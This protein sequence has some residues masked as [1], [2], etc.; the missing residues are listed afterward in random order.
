LAKRSSISLSRYLVTLVAALAAGGCGGGDEPTG[1]IP[2]DSEPI[3]RDAYV[4]PLGAAAEADHAR[5]DDAYRRLLI[6]RFTSMTPENAMKWAIIQPERGK[7]DFEEADALVEF[8]RKTGKRVRGHPLVWDDQLPRWVREGDWTPRELKRVMR[9]HIRAV[10]G[11]YRG[12]IAE[13][14]VVNEPLAH[15]GSFEHNIWFDTL[16]PRWVAYAFRVAR[17][18]DPHAKLFLNEIDAEVRGP[19]SR[20]LLELARTLKQ[21]GV[22]IDG[23]GFQHHTTGR[24]APN[25]ARLR[26]LFSATRGIG[27]LAAITEMDVGS[28]E[29]ARQAQVFA[30]AADVCAS[31]SN[32]TGLTVWGVTDAFSWLEPEAEALPFDEDGELKPAAAALERALRR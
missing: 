3:A 31:A 4:K 13:W 10:A 32:C 23:V 12:K 29:R 8:A 28:T 26:A 22:P 16:G 21:K 11:R 6:T 7:F 2:V 19:K 15:D 30:H 24:D 9:E 14:D 27:L 25:P 1:P 5:E 20:A 18:I 17:R